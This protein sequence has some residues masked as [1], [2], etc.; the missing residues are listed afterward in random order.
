MEDPAGDGAVTS[1]VD[2][3]PRATA[4]AIGDNGPAD[5]GNGDADEDTCCDSGNVSTA[6]PIATVDASALDATAPADAATGAPASSGE[7]IRDVDDV[8][9]VADCSDPGDD[10]T[11]TPAP[12]SLATKSVPFTD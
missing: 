8:A 6:E 9:D 3:G 7:V 4:A 1:P 12:R 2:A 11:S 5:G 10:A